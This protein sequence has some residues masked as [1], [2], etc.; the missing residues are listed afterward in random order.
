[1]YGPQAQF[2]FYNDP[3]FLVRSA[4]PP[5]MLVATV[6]KVILLA[7]PDQPIANVRT[8]EE[9]VH[10]SL[11]PRRATLI[12]LGLF[13]MVA[14]ALA[15]IGIYGVMSYAISQRTRE[16]SIRSALGA[17]RRDIIQLVLVGAMKPS[18]LGIVF[19]LAAAFTLARFVESQLFEVRAHDPLVFVSSVGLLGMAAALSVYFPA[20]RAAK[21]DPIVALR[22]E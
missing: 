8:L 9:A 13:A 19:G 10:Q 6:R 18:V 17:Q 12:L 22:A 3:S 14:I 7:D 20:R 11:A 16:L 1:V 15:A 2:K 4:L 5:S 21:V